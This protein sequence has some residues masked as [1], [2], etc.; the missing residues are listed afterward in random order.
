MKPW[1]RSR[2]F[3]NVLAIILTI[4][5]CRIFIWNSIKNYYYKNSIIIERI[6][7]SLNDF[8][9]SHYSD[10]NLNNEWIINQNVLQYSSFLISMNE[11][12]IQ[13]EVMAIVNSNKI[14]SLYDE[15]KCVLKNM[16]HM[17]L[18]VTKPFEII[19]IPLMDSPRTKLHKFKCLY[20]NINNIFINSND[21]R[22][23]LVFK[24]EYKSGYKNSIF[25]NIKAHFGIQ[26][27][28]YQI[29]RYINGKIPKKKGNKSNLFNFDYNL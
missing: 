26:F 16:N 23:A 18:Y 9:E 11:G 4:L 29:P 21:L 10:V 5:L 19:D 7:E 17:N 13:I 6:D 2:N 1:R 15:V 20:P 3:K 28:Q 12:H 8:I 24:N 27:I 14:S 22:V 25:D